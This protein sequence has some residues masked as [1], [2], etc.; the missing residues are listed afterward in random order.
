M[1][2]HGATSDPW[3]HFVYPKLDQIVQEFNPRYCLDDLLVEDLV[4]LEEYTRLRSMTSSHEQ[5]RQ[6][7][8]N[9]LPSRGPE[10]F[11]KFCDVL[12][13]TSNLSHLVTKYF[14]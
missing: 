14:L 6:L 11:Y 3:R 13:N 7:L 2:V 1:A 9:I 12:R 5:A 4:N 8:I 10:A